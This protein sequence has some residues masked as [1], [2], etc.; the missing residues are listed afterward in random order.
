MAHAAGS[1]STPTAKKSESA[2]RYLDSLHQP[3]M[4][5]T[6]ANQ[7]TTAGTGFLHTAPFFPS[8]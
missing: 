5:P 8:R 7:Q 3:G 4:I 2:A 6:P 1:N